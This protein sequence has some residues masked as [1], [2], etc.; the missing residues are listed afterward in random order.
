MDGDERVRFCG[1]CKKHVYNLSALEPDLAERLLEETDNGVCVTY[2]QRQDGTVLHGDCPVGQRDKRRR[3]L[4][5]AVGASV[6]AALHAAC[7]ASAAESGQDGGSHADAG[8]EIDP[9]SNGAID[10]VLPQ[11]IRQRP[12]SS[13]DHREVMGEPVAQPADSEHQAVTHDEETVRVPQDAPDEDVRDEEPCP[14]IPSGLIMGKIVPNDHP[15]MM[16]GGLRA[17][18]EE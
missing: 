14:G 17:P 1:S 12:K 15:A 16:T 9:Q 11:A 8:V 7:G 5:V 18:I 10:T 2:Y 13:V 4:V 3:S 6:V